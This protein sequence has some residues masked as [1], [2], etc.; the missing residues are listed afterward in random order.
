MKKI[1]A[2]ILLVLALAVPSYAEMTT[3]TL[4]NAA[5]IT[6]NG[7]STSSAVDLKR[8]KATG[9]F[10]VEVV[11]TAGTL[12]VEYLLSNDGTNYIEPASASDIATGLTSTNGPGGAGVHHYSFQPEPGRFMKIKVSETGNSEAGGVT[13][14]L[15]IN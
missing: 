15:L 13:V 8:Y 4:F 11:V 5:T 10:S 14:T 12:T 3:V 2:V 7:D 6:Q 9:Y 1:L